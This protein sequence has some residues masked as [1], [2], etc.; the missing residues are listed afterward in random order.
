MSKLIIDYDLSV[1]PAM[2]RDT[3]IRDAAP[4]LLEAAI[5]QQECGS[6]SRVTMYDEDGCEGWMWLHP[7]G[8]EWI[9]IGDWSETPTLHPLMRA[10]IAEAEGGK[11]D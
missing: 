8:R 6:P 2:D 1:Q 11:N 9:E 10:A 3:R 7:D 5:V 4:G